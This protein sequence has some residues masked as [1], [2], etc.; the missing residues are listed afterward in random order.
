MEDP[1]KNNLKEKTKTSNI[2]HSCNISTNTC[3][4]TNI[5]KQHIRSVHRKNENKPCQF[6][7]DTFIISC[8][9]IYIKILPV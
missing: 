1:S 6:C 9:P 3:I 7:K 4:Q 2:D 8:L 5:L